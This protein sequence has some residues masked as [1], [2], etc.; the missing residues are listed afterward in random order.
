MLPGGLE[1]IPLFGEWMNLGGGGTY[2]FRGLND[3]EQRNIRGGHGAAI[4]EDAWEQLA[5]F[6]LSETPCAAS[7]GQI[8][9]LKPVAPREA[10]FLWFLTRFFKWSTV[11]RLVVGLLIL[12][13]MI[14]CIM[15]LIV[16]LISVLG[17]PLPPVILCHPMAWM[18]GIILL[19]MAALGVLKNV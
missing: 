8:G 9:H 3:M 10:P 11:P 5:E 2:G 16:P 1:V 7:P 12:L 13:A 17:L 18:L 14:V 19:S 6:L 15:P 4:K